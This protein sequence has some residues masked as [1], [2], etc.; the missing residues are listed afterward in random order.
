M[1]TDNWHEYSQSNRTIAFITEQKSLDTARPFQ[2]PNLNITP[3]A[4]K[5]DKFQDL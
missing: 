3:A 4:L 2:E 5:L 1:Q